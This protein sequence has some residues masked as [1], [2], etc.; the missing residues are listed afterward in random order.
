MKAGANQA[1]MIDDL[2]LRFCGVLGHTVVVLT[3]GAGKLETCDVAR[4]RSYAKENE[5][6]RPRIYQRAS[7]GRWKLVE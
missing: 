6:H 7:K 1:T 5:A 3:D 2:E 4:A